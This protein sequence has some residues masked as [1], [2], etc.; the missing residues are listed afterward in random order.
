M[1]KLIQSKNWFHSKDPSWDPTKYRVQ[2][3]PIIINKAYQ[4]LSGIN[5][6]DILVSNFNDKAVTFY[7][8]TDKFDNRMKN[9]FLINRYNNQHLTP[10]WLTTLYSSLVQ[11]ETYHYIGVYE[12]NN[13]YNVLPDP[14][15]YQPSPF[16]AVRKKLRFYKK[17]K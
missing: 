6:G 17:Y 3:Y 15:Q 11:N 1:K 8:V 4:F 5:I 16:T 10:K 9:M 14:S 7:V 12:K 2:L 13:N